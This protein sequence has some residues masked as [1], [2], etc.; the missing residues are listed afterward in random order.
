MALKTYAKADD[1]PEGLRSE[2]KQS[3]SVWV[4][5]L[6]DDHPVLALNK[7]LIQE[8]GVEEAKVKKL[9]GD[10]DDALAVAKSTDVP[11]GQTLVSKADADLLDKYKAHGAPDEIAAKLTEHTA[12]KT[13]SD[14][15]KVEDSRR[16]VAKALGYDN[17]DAFIRLPNLPD[18]EIRGE[19]DKQT[20][21]A[22]VKDG[23]KII[24]RPATE[25]I[26]AD[27][28]PFLSALKTTPEGVTANQTGSSTSTQVDPFASAR[29][30]GEDYNKQHQPAQTL[31]QRFGLAKSA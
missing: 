21:I 6:A 26:E 3:G 22:K 23:E 28:A 29:K 12:L 14:Q 16:K 30:W 15:R 2:Y 11:R 19:G 9:R 24:E 1:I 5:D 7:T 13:E 20:V 31:E 25:V 17:V 4:P 10:L 8:K 27:F 18:F